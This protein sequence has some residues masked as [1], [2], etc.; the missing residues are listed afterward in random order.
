METFKNESVDLFLV[1]H[2]PRADDAN[3]ISTSAWKS[4]EN[5]RKKT[6]D[7][8]LQSEIEYSSLESNT[9]PFY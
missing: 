7:W 3:L 8:V 2:A 1:C 9:K 6:S 5:E 4:I